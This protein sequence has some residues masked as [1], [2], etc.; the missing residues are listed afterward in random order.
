MFSGFVVALQLISFSPQTV[1]GR[2]PPRA[3]PVAQQTAQERSF[4]QSEDWDCYRKGRERR[5]RCEADLP[6]GSRVTVLLDRVV[7]VD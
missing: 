7:E 1:H 3:V 4:S 6:G 2:R 5:T